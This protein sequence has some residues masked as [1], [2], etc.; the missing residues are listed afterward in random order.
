MASILTTLAT[1]CDAMV[2]LVSRYHLVLTGALHL[3]KAGGYETLSMSDERNCTGLNC[4]SYV[5][6]LPR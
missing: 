1:S 3:E 6:V 5:R 2:F 4:C